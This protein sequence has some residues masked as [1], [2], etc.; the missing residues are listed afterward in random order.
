[1]EKTIGNGKI[2]WLLDDSSDVYRRTAEADET[3]RIPYL[4]PSG[5]GQAW[6]DITHLSADIRLIKAT[7]IFTPEAHG[8]LV[9]LAEFEIN[10][11]EATFVVQYCPRGRIY[12]R[13]LHPEVELAYGG[14]WN[15]VRYA[16]RIHVQPLLDGSYDS[17]M[18]GITISRSAL[19]QLLGKD[20]TET[21][22][23]GLELHAMPQVKSISIPHHISSMLHD[24][25]PA[26]LSGQLRRLFI[27]AKILE[28]LCVLTNYVERECSSFKRLGNVRNAVRHLHDELLQLEGK[29]PS[30]NNLATQYQM[31]ARSLNDGFKRE[32]GL[33]IF[34]FVTDH[35]LNQAHSAL[36]NSLIPI[37]QL[38]ARL[39]Y[40]HVNHF[41][42]A[43]KRKYGYPPGALR[44]NGK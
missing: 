6:A 26:T 14:E 1:M 16:N 9:P 3:V 30:L 8:Q 27:Q 17:E 28:Y 32:F 29:L 31:S 44:H 36:T 33:S 15:L 38:A 10:Y 13:E 7:H 18:T 34:S 4:L 12:H 39:G 41:T 20:L 11:Q 2:R 25:T 24:C 21:L 40:S 43:F 42:V 23:Q 35:R 5:I 22:I 19:V 37:K